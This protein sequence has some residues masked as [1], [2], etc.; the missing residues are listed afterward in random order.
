MFSTHCR[1]M[2]VLRHKHDSNTSGELFARIAAL[3]QTGAAGTERARRAEH[4]TGERRQ[5][6]RCWEG[7]VKEKRA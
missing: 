7:D 6:D 4:D 1:V 3:T 2:L 5:S